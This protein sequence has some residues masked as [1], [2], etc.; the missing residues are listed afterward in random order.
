MCSPFA[1]VGSEIYQSVR[2]GRKGIGCELKTSYWNQSVRNL[3][4]VDEPDQDKFLFD[5]DEPTDDLSVIDSLI[6]NDIDQPTE[7]SDLSDDPSL[8]T[9]T[10]YTPEDIA[11]EPSPVVRQLMSAEPPPV[12]PVIPAMYA[13][14]T[15]KPRAK[16]SKPK[17][18]ATMFDGLE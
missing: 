5:V 8:D 16:K 10:E 7:E 1:G 14:E 9:P 11:D 12:E 18:A 4:T 6:T 17:A 2:M 15:A 3:A 13:P